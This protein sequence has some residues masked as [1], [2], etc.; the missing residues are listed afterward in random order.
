MF[1]LKQYYTKFIFFVII[2]E[3]CKQVIITT[4]QANFFESVT[5]VRSVQKKM[6]V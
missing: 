4:F 5:A 3:N 6:A 2:S 1:L